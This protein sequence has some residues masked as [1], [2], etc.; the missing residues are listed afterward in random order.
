M[1]RVQV[2]FR[3]DLVRVYRPGRRHGLVY[4]VKSPGRLASALAASSP[5]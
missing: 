5:V 2:L 4:R 1:A 3:H